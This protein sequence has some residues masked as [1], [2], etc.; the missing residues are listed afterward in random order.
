MMILHCMPLSQWENVRHGDCFGE[1]SVRAEGFVHCSSIEYFWRVAPNFRD[2]SEEL[3][4]LML[5]TDRISAEI[6]RE[7]GDG[8]GRAY[9]HVYGTIP[10][11]AVVQAL[12]FLRSPGGEWLK[13]P[14]LAAWQDR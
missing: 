11:D 6:R 9:P 14:E 5:D 10:T 7:D 12:P 13:N 3:V 1:D 8:C 2:A 4:L